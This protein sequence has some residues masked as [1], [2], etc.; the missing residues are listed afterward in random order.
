MKVPVGIGY[1]SRG[2]YPHMVG[3]AP[4]MQLGQEFEHRPSVG[5][6]CGQLGYATR[7]LY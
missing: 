3:G 6:M 4:V 2:M 7:L 1:V 5:E